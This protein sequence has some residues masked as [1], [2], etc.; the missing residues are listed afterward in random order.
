MREVCFKLSLEV[1]NEINK[2]IAN[3]KKD[4]PSVYELTVTKSMLT[5]CNSMVKIS[6]K[7]ANKC[8]STY[9]NDVPC[10][11]TLSKKQAEQLIATA[12]TDSKKGGS[13]EVIGEVLKPLQEITK[14]LLSPEAKKRLDDKLEQLRGRGVDD[15]LDNL[16]DGFLYGFSDPVKGAELFGRLVV[17]LGSGKDNKLIMPNDGR[18]F[19]TPDTERRSIRN[20]S[21][22]PQYGTGDELK[23]KEQ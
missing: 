13:V 20:L 18:T 10:K 14:K 15:E 12:T 4:Q 22:S 5:D 21:Y 6:E 17:N 2:A 16:R 7:S 23:K 3:V 11:I 9:V 19:A 8:K 1:I